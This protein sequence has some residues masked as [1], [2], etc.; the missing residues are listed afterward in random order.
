M[1]SGSP[2]QVMS[3]SCSLWTVT[4]SLVKMDTVP[5]S[6]VCPTLIS[7]DG[8]SSNESAC[9]A[10]SDNALNGSRV[11]YFALLT[12]P[13]AHAACFVDFRKMG[14]PIACLSRSAMY[15]LSAPES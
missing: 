6:Q 8:K 4:P 5:S 13:L 14:A 11:T 7:E 2:L 12:P 15:V 9:L 1:R 3:T 10:L